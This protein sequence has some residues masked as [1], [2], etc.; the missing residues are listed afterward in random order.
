MQNRIWGTSEPIHA[1]LVT[2]IENNEISEKDDAKE[3]SKK[4]VEKF[5]W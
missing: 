5:G 4:L 2:Q 1:D 3:R